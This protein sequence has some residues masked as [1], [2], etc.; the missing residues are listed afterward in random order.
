MAARILP[1]RCLSC[2]AN[3]SFVPAVPRFPLQHDLTGEVFGR[4]HVQHFFGMRSQ[5]KRAVWCCRCSCGNS[6]L[7]L[8]RSLRSGATHSCGCFGLEARAKANT[9]HGMSKTNL[10]KRWRTMIARCRNP[11]N[12][13]FM[14]Y[15]GRGIEICDRWN[16]FV[17]FYADMGEPPPGMTLERKNTDGPYSPENCCWATPMEQ[18]NNMRKNRLLTYNGITQTCAQWARVLGISYNTLS[19]RFRAGWTTEAM[20]TIPVGLY[21]GPQGQQ[22]KGI[23]AAHCAR[24]S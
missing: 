21:H 8:A 20:L 1:S 15:G 3:D 23:A 24:V 4:L 9:L 11:H 18:C 19:Y 14:N 13:E 10:H 17:N 16:K 5:P 2:K 22:V 12:P 6:S 7:V